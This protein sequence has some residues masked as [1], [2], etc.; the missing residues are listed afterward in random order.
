MGY[1]DCHPWEDFGD[2][3][4][5]TQLEL[6]KNGK[7]TRLTARSIYFA[8]ADA[9]ARAN[10]ENLLAARQIPMS[11]YLISYLDTSALDEM[12]KA[13][14][15]G[16]THFKIKLGKELDREE[17]LLKEAIKHYP[18][19][20]FR[21]DFNSKLSKDQFI[22]FL[23]RLSFANSSIDYI[24]DPFAFNYGAWRQIQETFLINLAADGH[25]KEAYGHPEAAKVLIMKPAIH[26][27]KPVSTGQKLIVTS[28]LD[29][30]VGQMS[31]AYMAS[32]A[33]KEPCGLLSH[34]TYETNPFA[35]MI[36]HQGPWIHAVQ[37]YGFGFD[38]LLNKQQFLPL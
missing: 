16:F 18:N 25:Y 22:S 34:F 29:H 31:A 6:L 7:C 5:S 37:G 38:E 28:Y 35:Q 17:G 26:T 30:P 32:F 21:L 23:D 14:S 8:K 11:H 20:K 24:E 13:F 27:L 4:L 3:P 9:N 33:A 1:A 36:Q 2:F 19:A 10:K 15:N 12:G